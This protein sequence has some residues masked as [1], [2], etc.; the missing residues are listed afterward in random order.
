MKTVKVTRGQFQML[1]R[2]TRR[3]VGT[4]KREMS[5][6]GGFILAPAKPLQPETPTENAV[7]IVEAF[8]DDKHAEPAGAGDVVQRA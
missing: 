3:E 4:L 8:T 6:G 1:Q 5:K 7:A 2:L